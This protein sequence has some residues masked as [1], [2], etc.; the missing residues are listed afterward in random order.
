M[1]LPAIVIA[2]GVVIVQ[3]SGAITTAANIVVG[4]DKSIT[5]AIDLRQYVPQVETF[6]HPKP[7]PKKI[8]AAKRAPA[9]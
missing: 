3:A 5:A 9:K 6:L 2:A 4:I 8:A 7:P 1:P